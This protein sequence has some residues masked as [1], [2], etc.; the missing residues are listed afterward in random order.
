MSAS[1]MTESSDA[2]RKRFMNG[3]EHLMSVQRIDILE[4]EL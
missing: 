1:T 4:Y 3:R 2:N